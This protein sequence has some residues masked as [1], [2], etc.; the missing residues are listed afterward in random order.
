MRCPCGVSVLWAGMRRTRRVMT[1]HDKVPR[2]V[3][4]DN[5]PHPDCGPP[6]A[7]PSPVFLVG[8]VAEAK[9]ARRSGW[10]VTIGGGTSMGAARAVRRLIQ[11][12]A[13]GL[14]SFGLAGGLDPAL[15]PGTLV[16]PEAVI[17]D[18][19]NWRTDIALGECLGG[20]T[21]H[22]CLGLDRIVATAA[23]KHRLRHETGAD[24]VDMESGAVAAIASAA[25]VPFA[26]LRAICDPADRTLPPAALIAL[27]PA[28]HLAPARI[29]WSVVTSPAQAGALL[30]LARDAAAA[31]RALRSRIAAM[32]P[33][34]AVS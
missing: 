14:V 29:A 7:N 19:C 3:T 16:V 1:H 34:V 30:V 17:A 12:G 11:G 6:S 2:A 28:G 33:F 4:I 10:P 20:T 8:F 18:G 27:D 9:I 21:G 22:V 32:Q 23:E 25:G 31:R 26:V 13:T 24:L 15:P 5:R